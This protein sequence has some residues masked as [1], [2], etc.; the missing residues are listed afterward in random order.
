[1]LIKPAF[2][3]DRQQ[4]LGI[5]EYTWQQYL[6]PYFA[7]YNPEFVRLLTAASEQPRLRTFQPFRS[8]LRLGFREPGTEHA[9]TRVPTIELRHDEPN[10]FV[11]CGPDRRELG[12]GD[13]DTVIALVVDE[14]E[15]ILGPAFP[16]ID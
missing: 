10:R 7:L 13:V 12:S 6:D 5:A 11:V 1:M 8:M 4:A 3:R 2:D 9:L 15:R 14:A 16:E